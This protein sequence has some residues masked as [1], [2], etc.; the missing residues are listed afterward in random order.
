MTPTQQK[1]EPRTR[2]EIPTQPEPVPHAPVPSAGDPSRQSPAADPTDGPS[3]V[4]VTLTAL[5][6]LLVVLCEFVVLHTVYHLPDTVHAEQRV[7]AEAVGALSAPQ[8]SGPSARITLTALT[9]ALDQLGDDELARSVPQAS[10]DV[11]TARAEVEALADRLAEREAGIGRRATLLFVLLLAVASVGWMFWFKQ[12]VARH[13]RLEQ[14]VTEQRART[15]SDQ[16]LAGLVNSSADLVAVCDRESRIS[17]VTPSVR[18]VLGIDPAELVGAM[19]SS[20][21]DPDD[22]AAYLGQMASVG[23]ERAELHVRLQHRDGRTLHAEG[24]IT[25]LL[26]DEAV[27]GLVVTVRD[28]TERVEL[29]ERLTRHAFDDPLTGLHNR[30]LLGDRLGHALTVRAED[31]GALAVLFCDLDDFKEVNDRLGHGAGDQVL[32][33]VG[34]R[35]AATMRVEDTCAR[36]GGDEFAVLMERSTMAEA[37]AAA[38]RLQ[39]A[40]DVELV[41]EGE[42]LRVRASLGLAPGVPGESSSEEV[43]RNADVAMYLAKERGK[44]QVAT[45]E[46]RLHTEA[47]ARLQLRSDLRTALDQ[48]DRV[49]AP[50]EPTAGGLIV[51]YQPTVD[52]QSGGIVGFEALVRWEHPVRGLLPPL[53]FVP[54]AEESGLIVRLG[55]W[56]LHEACQ[57]VAG[58]HTGGL[59]PSIAVNVAAQQLCCASFLD[60]VTDALAASGLAAHHLVLE[61]TESVV[62]ADIEQVVP[63]LTALRA[64]GV[65]IAIDDFGTGYNSLSYLNKLPLDIL[66][67]DKS[68]V[69]S[70]TDSGQAASVTAAIIAMSRTMQLETVAEGVEHADQ[71]QWLIGELCSHGQGYLWS[72]PVELAEAGRLLRESPGPFEPAP[73]AVVPTAGVTVG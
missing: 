69:D 64:L 6:T 63:R 14:Q 51:H 71:A 5:S 19:W 41:V 24:T 10:P 40:L 42:V 11:P 53:L 31:A 68:F 3:R 23:G 62:L 46:P 20:L 39:S 61:I 17:Y 48:A 73:T 25:N 18:T 21:V 4:R 43:L 1:L 45:Y 2:P 28:V 12:L 56:V 16:R 58:L 44:G 34:R 15:R 49:A 26:E 8:L 7:V 54:V 22:A 60:D 9:S 52:L 66:K 33:E 59:T 67:V 36:L 72:R 57:A 37:E 47:L 35:I 13:R 32:V 50:G 65:K 55:R 30:R 38:A 70:V 27:G 29:E